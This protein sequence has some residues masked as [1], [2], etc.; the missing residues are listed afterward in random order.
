MTQQPQALKLLGVLF[1]GAVALIIVF[2]SF[3]ALWLRG[4][5]AANVSASCKRSGSGDNHPPPIWPA[6]FKTAPARIQPE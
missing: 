6:E 3:D 4:H 5:T 2:A 1:C